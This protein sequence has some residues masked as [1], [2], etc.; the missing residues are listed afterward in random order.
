ML[1]NE[2]DYLDTLGPFL[3]L[4]IRYNDRFAFFSLIINL[5]NT[6]GSKFVRIRNIKT[7]TF[8]KKPKS[9]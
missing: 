5:T 6:K 3:S 2:K 8:L 4:H 9:S 7:K 1:I